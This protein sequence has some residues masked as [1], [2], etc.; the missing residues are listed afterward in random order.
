[1]APDYDKKVPE[2]EKKVPESDKKYLKKAGGNID[3]NVV[4]ITIKMRTLV[5]IIQ[6]IFFS[7]GFSLSHQRVNCCGTRNKS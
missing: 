4:Q 5:R 1:M 7:F 6:N 2:F 3:L